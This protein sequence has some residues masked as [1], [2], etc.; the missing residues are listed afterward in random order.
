MLGLLNIRS[1]LPIGCDLVDQP[2]DGV[3]IRNVDNYGACRCIT[4]LVD[5]LSERFSGCL[6]DVG[7]HYCAASG[8]QGADDRGA[9]ARP[10]TCHDCDLAREG[11]RRGRSIRG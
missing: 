2:G 1:R 9:D 5:L 8:G 10:A 4:R 7:N 3:G 6:V 11:A